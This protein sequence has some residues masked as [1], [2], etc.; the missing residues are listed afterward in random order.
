MRAL[1][2][3]AFL[4]GVLVAMAAWALDAGCR[5]ARI[6][7]RW[8]W[9]GALG[10][11]LA[12]IAAAPLRSGTIV[13]SV[14]VVGITEARSTAL[15]S[16]DITARFWRDAQAARAVIA[17]SARA[18]L[19]SIA[20]ALPPA[21]DRRIAALWIATTLLTLM[22]FA[23]AY[24]RLRIVMR[25]LPETTLRDMAVRVAPCTGPAVVG[26]RRPQI[27]VPEWI[28]RR[29]PDEQRLVAAH[30]SEH[31]DAGDH[32]LL[33]AGCAAAVLLPWHPAVWWMLARLRLAVEVDCDRRV[34]AR[35]AT[36]HAY[37]NML[38][39]LAACC[40]DYRLGVPALADSTSH[41]ER[42]I[43]AMTAKHSS[44]PGIRTAA[45][46]LLAAVAL[47]VACEAKAPTAAE[48]N[49]VD[50]GSA[51]RIAT[52]AGADSVGPTYY[53]D[54][55]RTTA[56]DAHRIAAADIASVNVYK[57]AGHAE[58]RI[59]T[60]GNAQPSDALP[61]Q[62]LRIRTAG[63]DSAALAVIYIDG[64]LSD[65]ATLQKLSKA[66]I[67]SVEVIKGQRARELY[68]DDAAA[69]NGVI[70]VVTKR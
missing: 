15:G 65:M 5:T 66:D 54:G 43:V 49:A 44:L 17:R 31:R 41:L 18:A 3:Y 11:S 12:L 64:Q 45:F 59:V 33:A 22:F 48:V 25:R 9:A 60:K 1:V 70:R 28:F 67:Q 52:L 10:L 57:A 63:V 19:S 53:V 32:M 30:E 50:A 7:R 21:S 51:Q 69:A 40:S 39:D 55:V 27:I 20:G 37:G 23:V 8:T 38:I 62:S 58:I 6:P 46:G 42:R 13:T 47:L 36:P 14:R 68:P 56:A 61:A 29:S 2:A 26:F 4:T 16:A 35:E 24:V 34:L